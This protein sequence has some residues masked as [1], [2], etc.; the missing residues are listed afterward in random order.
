M[1]AASFFEDFEGGLKHRSFLLDSDVESLTDVMTNLMPKQTADMDIKVYMDQATDK[2][3]AVQMSTMYLDN[4]DED[5]EG[6]CD[7]PPP[8]QN[9]EYLTADHLDPTFLWHKGDANENLS[10]RAPKPVKLDDPFV[11]MYKPAD[12]GGDDGASGMCD[13]M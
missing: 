8:N 11:D 9:E 10:A 7:T 3:Q 5:E 1:D 12:M 4:D 2:N 13:M 6:L